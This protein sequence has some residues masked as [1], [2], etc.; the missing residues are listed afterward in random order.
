MDCRFVEKKKVYLLQYLKWPLGNS[1]PPSCLSD[2]H[3]F[4]TSMRVV[5][6]TVAVLLQPNFQFG[7]LAVLVFYA[8]IV[9]EQIVMF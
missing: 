9:S 7:L 3:F 5:Q 2:T 1:A 4:N 6:S 8:H